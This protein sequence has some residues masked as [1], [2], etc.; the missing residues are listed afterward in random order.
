MVFISG[1][2]GSPYIGKVSLK[3][4][5]RSGKRV[6]VISID[7]IKRNQ[8]GSVACFMGA[9]SVMVEKLMSGTEVCFVGQS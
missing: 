9:P 3:Q 8:R 6:K 4:M 1:G 2:G 7:S 5:I